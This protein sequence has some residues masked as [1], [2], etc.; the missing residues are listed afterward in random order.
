MKEREYKHSPTR[1]KQTLSN[2]IM[3][4]SLETSTIETISTITALQRTFYHN[5]TDPR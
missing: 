5:A 2:Y 3:L 1:T 4:A